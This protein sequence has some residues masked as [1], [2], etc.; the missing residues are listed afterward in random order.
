MNGQQRQP[1]LSALRDALEKRTA[2]LKKSCFNDFQTT[3]FAQ[4]RERKHA[5]IIHLFSGRYGFYVTDLVSVT[6][7]HG[8]PRVDS[9]KLP[10][11]DYQH[12]NTTVPDIAFNHAETPP[13]SP[14][15]CVPPF[16]TQSGANQHAP[17][18]YFM[19]L[20]NQEPHLHLLTATAP[21]TEKKWQHFRTNTCIPQVGMS[22]LPIFEAVVEV[23][24][25]R[26]LWIFGIVG[27]V[28]RVD[29]K[30]RK[31]Y[32][33]NIM[34]DLRHLYQRI[35]WPKAKL[36]RARDV[37]TATATMQHAIAPA[38]QIKDIANLEREI[39]DQT[40]QY[41][42]GSS[43]TNPYQLQPDAILGSVPAAYD[44][45]M[46]WALS[47][48]IKK[49]ASKMLQDTIVKTL[50]PDNYFHV[51]TKQG[52]QPVTADMLKKAFLNLMAPLLNNNKPI[53][54]QHSHWHGGD[55]DGWRQNKLLRLDLNVS[56]VKNTFIWTLQDNFPSKRQLNI[57]NF[58][59]AYHQIVQGKNQSTIPISSCFAE[60]RYC[61]PKMTKKEARAAKLAKMTQ[62]NMPKKNKQKKKNVVAISD[63]PI[64]LNMTYAE[65]AQNLMR[66]RQTIEEKWTKGKTWDQKEANQLSKQSSKQRSKQRKHARRRRK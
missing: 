29:G 36:S 62:H 7:A 56:K 26:P 64:Q 25:G 57:S 44:V 54:I 53:L 50:E 16:Q 42:A 34:P 15:H 20:P 55:T 18:H 6:T 11:R 52:R 3:G 31:L 33:I 32:G 43:A 22:G 2:G 23:R 60:A 66:H 10:Q 19:H 37:L 17:R 51:Q 38:H 9:K 48:R 41:R 63:K 27:M 61:H 35:T 14:L 49:T 8:T 24:H 58:T 46:P 65:L 45:C 47:L 13:T 4:F 5:S 59:T 28:I 12:D 1:S 39:Q 30:H 21:L 40:T